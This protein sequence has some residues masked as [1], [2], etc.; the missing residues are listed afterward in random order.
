MVD[1]EGPPGVTIY[2]RRPNICAHVPRLLLL[3][4]ILRCVLVCASSTCASQTIKT[5]PTI[6]LSGSKQKWKWN[7]F[8]CYFCFIA[9][10]LFLFC[11]SCALREHC[12]ACG[13]TPRRSTIAWPVKT[14]MRMT[15]SYRT[16]LFAIICMFVCG[17]RRGA[18][19]LNNTKPIRHHLFQRPLRPA[20]NPFAD[21]FLITLQS[22]GIWIA[23]T[24]LKLRKRRKKTNMECLCQLPFSWI[25]TGL[26]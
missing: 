2:I 18:S 15:I 17:L 6:Q 14:R 3:L 25:T 5:P 11:F 16:E 7:K 23:Q 20:T 24:I 1:P 13:F 9:V 10:V 21:H 4:A 26:I 12:I 19:V 8:V 22:N